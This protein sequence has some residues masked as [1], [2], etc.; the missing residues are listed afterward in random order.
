MKGSKSDETTLG[1]VVKAIDD[2]TRVML[3]AQGQ[4]D[5]RSEAI[6]RL[7]Q[8]GISSPR[9]A[10]ILSLRTKDVASVVAKS[11]RGKRPSTDSA[12]QSANAQNVSR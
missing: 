11:T 1:D 4:F 10:A 12:D 6:R 5:S 9:I 3:S 7:S 2:L 8:L